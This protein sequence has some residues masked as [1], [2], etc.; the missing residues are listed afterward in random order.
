MMSS[1]SLIMDKPSSVVSFPCIKTEMDQ[2]DLGAHCQTNH[3]QVG[4]QL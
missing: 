2:M 4:F 1:G 3:L